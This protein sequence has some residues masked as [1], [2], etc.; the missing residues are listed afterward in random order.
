MLI[1][2]RRSS[3]NYPLG[4]MPGFNETHPASRGIGPGSG[5]VGVAMGD[6]FLNLLDGG[7]GTK[8]GGGAIT[9]NYSEF[10]PAITVTGTS[11]LTYPGFPTTFDAANTMGAIYW[12][13]NTTDIT[14]LIHSSSAN[15]GI[16]LKTSG[17]GLIFD[18]FGGTAVTF[19]SSLVAQQ[20]LFL[21]LS[22]HYASQTVNF[23]VMNLENGTLFKKVDTGFLAAGTAPNGTYSIG[24]SGSGVSPATGRLCASM[25]SPAYLSMSELVQWAYDPWSFW[26]PPVTRNTITVIPPFI[27]TLMPQ[28][29]L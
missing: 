28:I 15:N 1:D 6:N 17:P 4:A 19:S 12:L 26:Y 13:A 27:H 23:V 14:F 10:G 25:M 16:E 20:M 24:N 11:V 8:S 7:V 21:G 29:L 18:V 2:P 9:A 5:F 22:G 3:L